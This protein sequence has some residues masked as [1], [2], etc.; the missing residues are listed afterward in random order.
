MDNDL[1]LYTTDDGESRLALRQLGGQLWLTQLEMA[2]LYQ[3]S[4]QNIGKHVKAMLSDGE[5]AEEA[6]VNSK[7]TT[8]A[9][10]KQYLTQLAKSQPMWLFPLLNCLKNN[11]PL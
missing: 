2:E 6:V 11:C 8:A 1:I 4:K 7:F 10:G 9:D 5:L 3:T